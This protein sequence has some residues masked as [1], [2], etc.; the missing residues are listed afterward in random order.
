[1]PLLENTR[2]SLVIN[3]PNDEHDKT[4]SHGLPPPR[5]GTHDVKPPRVEVLKGDTSQTYL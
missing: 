1:M 2:I 4:A 3:L 5:V